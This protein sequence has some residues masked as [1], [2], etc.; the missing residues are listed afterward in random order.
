LT[1]GVLVA[2]LVGVAVLAAVEKL[3]GVAVWMSVVVAGLAA[4]LGGVGAL[5]LRWRDQRGAGRGTIRRSLRGTQ[6]RAADRLPRTGA[7]DLLTLR[8]HPAIVELA[9]VRRSGKEREVTGYLRAGR[10]VLLVGS[11]MVGKT[12][13]AAEVVREQFPSRPMAIPDSVAALVDLDKADLILRGHVIWLDDLDRFLAGGGVTAGLVQR[14]ARDNIVLATLRAGEWDRFQPT[15]QLRPPEWDVLAIFEV[16]TLDRD[17]DQPDAEALAAAVP[18]PEVRDRITRV[19]IGEYVGAA[20]HVRDRLTIGAQSNPLGYSL[21]RGAV[22]WHRTGLTRPVPADLLPALASAH[23]TPRQR[24][25]LGDPDSYHNALRWATKEITTTV[26]LLEPG[27]GTYTVYDYALDQL[28]AIEQPIPAN[29]WKLV[30]DQAT[31][32][33]LV[34]IGYQAEVSHGLHEHAKRAWRRAAD[35]DHPG[36][37]SNLG[38]LLQQRGEVAEAETWYRRAADHDH[39]GA[40]FNLGVLLKQRGEVAEAQTWYR[41]AAARS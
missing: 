9:Y 17:R 3:P 23:L 5:W 27:Q 13:L 11:S 40:M 35:R 38:V 12:R 18:D 31:D 32:D 24:N 33:E 28:M 39:P 19:G 22:D 29:T 26:S 10:P 8:V 30:L 34:A 36:A 25:S 14:L 6:G 21:V 1:V 4:A 37:M 41:R 16:V 7:V 15:A 2:V 20:R